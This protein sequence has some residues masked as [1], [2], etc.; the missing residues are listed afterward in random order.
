MPPLPILALAVASFGIGTTE[1]VIMGLLPEVAQSFGV[2]IPQAGYLVSG[3]AMGVVV[4]APIVAIATAGLPRKTALL[5]LMA[6]F[7]AGNL[8]C[9]LAPSYGLLMAARILTAFAHGAFFGI[10][11]VVARDLVPRE[12]RTQAV[13]L[14]FAGLTLA[15][16]LGVPLGTALGQEAGWRSTFWAVVV[17]GLAAGLAIQLCVP[18]GLPGTRGRLI[19]EFRALGRWPVLRPMLISTLS[20]VSFFTVFTYVTPFLTGVTGFTPQG[21]TGVLFAAGTGLTVGN[22]LGGH[23]AD[24]GPMAT[25]IGSFLG[26]V[27]ALLV[28][29]AVA[30]HPALTVAVVVLWSGLVFALVSPLQ[31]WVVEAASDAPNLASTL[32]QGAFNLGNA[33]GAWIGGTALTLGAGYGQLPLIAAAVSLAGLGLVLTAVS[34]GRQGAA[35][36]SAPRA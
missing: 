9:A 30:H 32:N 15:N 21:V 13:S 25:I 27:A 2:T 31:I 34:R 4:G 24:R 26:I 22:L 17:I 12:K 11:A 33:A 19:S 29:A 18:D 35:P 14:M 1:F 6:V 7:L 36:A 8:G 20:S 3:Y 23:L 5:A 16:V 10:G 28:L